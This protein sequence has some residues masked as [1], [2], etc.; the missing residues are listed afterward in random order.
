MCSPLSSRDLD[1]RGAFGTERTDLC[2]LCPDLDTANAADLALDAAAARHVGVRVGTR[3][4]A[5]C[6]T[7]VCEDLLR[8]T[9]LARLDAEDHNALARLSRRWERRAGKAPTLYAIVDVAAVLS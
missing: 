7:A 2:T 1:Q 3:A 5:A 9:Y 8:A 6:H 4:C